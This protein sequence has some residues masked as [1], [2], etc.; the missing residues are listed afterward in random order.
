MRCAIVSGLAMIAL[1]TG[2]ASTPLASLEADREAKRFDSAPNAAMIY[3]Y[4]PKGYGGHGVSTIWINDRLVGQTLP[5][6][7]YRVPVRPG[8]ARINVS[9]HDPGRLEFDTEAG[10]VYYVEAQVA[11]EAQSESNTVFRRVAPEIGQPAIQ[12]C[13]RL[14]ETWRQIGRAHV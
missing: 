11:G 3:V 2:C 14:L 8:R 1:L 7:F 6:T 4:R 12:S 9:G 10:G 5:E 13:C